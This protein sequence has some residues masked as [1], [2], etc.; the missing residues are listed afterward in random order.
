VENIK[1]YFDYDQIFLIIGTSCDKDIS[2]MVKEL[3]PLS[4]RVVVTR[5]SHPRAASPSAV[6]AEFISQGIEPEFSEGVFQALSRTSSLA[7]KKD[8]ICV[9]GSLFVV[10]EALD[11]F[12]RD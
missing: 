9:T 2:E 12:S 11:Y 1:T 10:A 3:V 4:P 5:S 7:D 8:L 6:A